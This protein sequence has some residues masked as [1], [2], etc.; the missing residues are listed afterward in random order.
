MS[1][2]GVVL[3]RREPRRARSELVCGITAARLALETELGLTVRATAVAFDP[4]EPGT[5]AGLDEQLAGIAETNG[6]ML[7]GSDDG[8]GFRWIGFWGA[9]LDDLALAVAMVAEAFDEAGRW[10]QLV[11]GVFTFGRSSG[12]DVCWIYNFDR[13]GFYAFVS[14]GEDRRDTE[15]ELRLHAAVAH[16]LRLEPDPQRRYPVWDVPFAGY[17]TKTP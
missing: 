4:P 8:F 2:V 15:E 5:V 12:P 6:A 11:C 7:A 14:L 1:L 9:S 16:D 3:G 10:E 13:G 17:G